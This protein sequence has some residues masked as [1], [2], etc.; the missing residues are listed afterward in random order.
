M[1]IVTEQ[2]NHFASAMLGL[3]AHEVA[4]PEHAEHTL[5]QML[6]AQTTLCDWAQVCAHVTPGSVESL[7]F[8]SLGQVDDYG[9]SHQ[10]EPEFYV[11]KLCIPP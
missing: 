4:S 5:K 11:S 9:A 3:E 1:S 7:R 10:V 8:C 2:V 6:A